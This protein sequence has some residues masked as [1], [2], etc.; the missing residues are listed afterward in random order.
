MALDVVTGYAKAAITK[1]VSSSRMREGF[2]RKGAE[3]GYI[4]VACALDSLS[5]YLLVGTEVPSQIAT[6]IMPLTVMGASA[7]IIVME[8]TSITENMKDI[9]GK[10]P[11]VERDEG[12]NDYGSGEEN[13]VLS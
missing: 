12:M 13:G 10:H 6:A 7:Y 5:R 4:V 2:W 11:A 9:T 1:T 3:L 8:M